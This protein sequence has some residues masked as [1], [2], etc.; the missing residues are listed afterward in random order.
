MASIRSQ[1][2]WVI[3]LFAAAVYFWYRRR[4]INAS[5]SDPVG[6]AE[7]TRQNSKNNVILFCYRYLRDILTALKLTQNFVIDLNSVM[8]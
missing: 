4:K 6:N 5:A 7:E 3:P 2:K 8:M 1:L